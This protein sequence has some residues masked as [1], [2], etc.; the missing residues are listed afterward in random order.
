MQKLRYYKYLVYF[1]KQKEK[2]YGKTT[3]IKTYFLV[4]PMLILLHINLYCIVQF[5]TLYK[6]TLPGTLVVAGVFFVG[7]GVAVG[8]DM[9]R[10]RWSESH[11]IG[12]ASKHYL[13]LRLM[14]LLGSSMSNKIDKE[15]EDFMKVSHKLG[16]KIFLYE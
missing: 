13:T 2:L 15:S 5:V 3:T 12:S 7:T 4:N 1:E 14:K 11:T 9:S 8:A 16:Y 6:Y 10:L